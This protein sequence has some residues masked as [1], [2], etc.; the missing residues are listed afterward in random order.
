MSDIGKNKLLMMENV[1]KNLVKIKSDEMYH[2]NLFITCFD[3][4]LLVFINDLRI[5]FNDTNAQNLFIFSK[6]C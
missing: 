4:F 1:A 3:S 2:I 5:D 6:F